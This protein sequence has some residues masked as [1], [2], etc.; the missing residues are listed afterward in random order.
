MTSHQPGSHA[1]ALLAGCILLAGCA[2]QPAN[3]PAPDTNTMNEPSPALAPP[4]AEQRPHVVESPHGNRADHY[5][6][7]RDDDRK[8]PD[9]LAYLAAENAYT[10]A[11]LAH[12][13]GLEDTLFDELVARIKK[14]DSS[15]PARYRGYYYYRRFETDAEYPIYARR[16]GS[17]DAPEEILL[18]V[19]RLAEGHDYF[20]VGD[21]EVSTNNKLLAWSEDTSGRRI[22]TIR[23]LNLATG[24][25]LPDALPGNTAAV[26]WADDNRTLFY[27][28][29]D[30][31]TLLGYRVRKHRLGDDPAD[32]ELVYEE[33][34][35][36]FYMDLGRT[37]DDRFIVMHLNSTVADEI[38][39]LDASRPD[40]P[41]QVLLPR[42]R[43]HEYEADHI[44]T[45]WIIRTNW[46]AHNFRIVSAPDDD[47]ENRDGWRDIVPHDPNVYIAEFDAFRDF[48]AIAE[49]RDALRRV[50]V[51]S[52]DG[53]VEFA[54]QSDEPAFVMDIDVNPEQDTDWLRYNYSSLTTPETIYE[55]NTKTQERRLLKQDE[56]LGGFEA[57]NYRTERLSA[58]ARD[59]K[60]IPVSIV[61]RDG[62]RRDGT[63]PLYQDGY[64]AYGLSEDPGFDAD[65]LSLLD[66]GFIYAIAHIRGGQELGRQWYEDGKLLNKMN[67][68][69]DFIDVTE[70]LVRE[71][72]ADPDRMAAVGRSAGGLLTGAV[73]NLRPDLY[74]VV[75]AGVPYVDAVTTMLDESI[76]LTTGEFDEWGNPKEQR[77]YDY[78]LAYSPYDNVAAM[79]YPA[80]FVTTGLWDGAV[81]YYEPAK[82]VARL[83][84][85]KTD[86]NRL[87]FH[88]HMDAGHSGQSGRFRANREL[89][90]EFA[91]IMDEFGLAAE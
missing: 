86:D 32:D 80:M 88:T 43:D 18:D 24:E 73:V 27:I 12:V 79:D 81:Q 65:V 23:F 44:G 2:E 63:A 42:E 89:A 46:Q 70:F 19:N 10:L 39:Y 67:T 75:V 62:Y 87:L 30:P 34:D 49:R 6:W 58:P 60:R 68:F 61:Y 20:A 14:D 78:M 59:G 51:L 57:S 54:V 35:D 52:W 83:R 74:R 28:E 26:V 53:E 90:R 33:A 66:R 76:P 37:G 85:L 17:V 71:K 47:V 16:K 7:L 55:I 36:T 11:Q 41:F 25:L 22:Y 9:M 45:R 21:Y 5:Y 38:R 4:V 48:L 15:V 69:T 31:V 13:K 91:F 1:H 40:D 72:Y 82:W 8:D 64:G 77:Y 56:V 50:R 84:E 29:K 3:T